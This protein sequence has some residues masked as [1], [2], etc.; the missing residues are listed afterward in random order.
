MGHSTQ[1]AKLTGCTVV[2]FDGFCPVAYKSYG[3]APGTF[4]TE[5]LRSGKSFAARQGLFVA[6]GSLNGLACAAKITEF[7]IEE[8]IGE[9][10]GKAIR[11]AI[12]GAVVYDLGTQRHQ[13]DAAYGRE[14]ASEVTDKPVVNGNVGGGTGT[15]VGK[16]SC[17]RKGLMLAMKAGVGSSRIDL[18]DGV[19]I[20]AL[21]VVNALGNVVLP[22]GTIL[23]G[24]RNDVSKPKFRTFEGSSNFLTGRGQ[25]TTISIVGINVD[26]EDYA[27][28][29]NVAH[30][31]SQG[32]IRAIT[33]VNTSVDG[34]TVFVFSTREIKS[35]LTPLGKTISRNG[36]DNLHV[37]IIG[38]AAAK[39]VQESIYNACYKAES[40]AFEGA[41]EGIVPSCKDYKQ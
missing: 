7:M 6:G 5:N 37:D 14:A 15:S 25:N 8:G 22:D 17:T 31:A 12:S 20:C 40:I 33:P 34:D 9:K 27:N 36:W 4:S 16:F 23:A 1:R 2:L 29:E 21:S 10:V 13:Y 30:I 38:H 41:F 18:G 19:T 26:L 32:Q 39:A 35:F 11:P 24:N 3:G 28:Y